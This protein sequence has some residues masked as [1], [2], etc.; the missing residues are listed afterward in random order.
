MATLPKLQLEIHTAWWFRPFSW[1]LFTFWFL[2]LLLI[3]RKTTEAEIG[4]TA[5]WICD[6]AVR[7]ELMR[8]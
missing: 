1:A 4:R 8:T 2:R 3:G 6:H 7:V 5:Q